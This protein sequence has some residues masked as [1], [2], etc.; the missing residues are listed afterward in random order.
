MTANHNY[1]YHLSVYA[2]S[3]PSY[4]HTSL[5]VLS[6]AYIAMLSYASPFLII[7]DYACYAE[8][9]LWLAISAVLDYPRICLAKLS[10]DYAC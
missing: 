5:D 2:V 10:Y 6:H 8:Q 9:R 4:A 3:I 7:L 1:D